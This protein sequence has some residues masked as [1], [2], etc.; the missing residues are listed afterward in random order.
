MN[1]EKPIGPRRRR[2]LDALEPPPARPRADGFRRHRRHGH[3]RQLRR[4][5]ARALR[6]GRK[7]PVKV[8]E[9]Y[10]MLGEIEDDLQATPWASTSSRSDRPQDACSASSNSD[11]KPC[12]CSTALACSCPAGFNVTSV[13]A[14]RRHADLSAGRLARRP[15]GGCR[16]AAISST[17]IIRQPPIDEDGSTPPT[18]LEEF[19]PLIARASSTLDARRTRAARDTATRVLASTSAARPSATSRWCRPRC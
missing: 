17:A 7:R 14:E 12:D 16:R 6:A 13:D 19:G 1:S 18:T 2:V 10:Q 15:A 3:A 4:R 8:S 11:W 5:A 9:P